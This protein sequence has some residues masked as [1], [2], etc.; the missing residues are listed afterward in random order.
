MTIVWVSKFYN[1]TTQ[2]FRA[3]SKRGSTKFQILLR[4]RVLPNLRTRETWD[5]NSTTAFSSI[6]TQGIYK[7]C[8][9][10]KCEFMNRRELRSCTMCFAIRVEIFQTF[11]RY[12][13]RFRLECPYLS[14][15]DINT[16]V[17]RVKSCAATTRHLVYLYT[18]SASWDLSMIFRFQ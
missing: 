13:H 1:M 10:P 5:C 7:A 15:I 18:E 8:T 3:L 11:P 16:V 17:S 2:C 6:V 14:Q 4:I 12:S 9:F